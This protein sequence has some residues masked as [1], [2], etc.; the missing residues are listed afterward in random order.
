MQSHYPRQT[1]IVA[2]CAAITLFFLS[3]GILRANPETT[4]KV[5]NDLLDETQYEETSGFGTGGDAYDDLDD[6]AG[7]PAGG[8]GSGSKKIIYPIQKPG[9]SASGGNL[10][11]TLKDLAAGG[12]GG[13][14]PDTLGEIAPDITEEHTTS[15][16]A[17]FSRVI[18]VEH[19]DEFNKVQERLV[20]GEFHQAELIADAII[21]E[22]PGDPTGYYLSSW[23]NARNGKRE[24]ALEIIKRGLKIAP[25]H[26]GLQ[27]L[28]K[29]LKRKASNM[30]QKEVDRRRNQLLGTLTNEDAAGD[31]GPG[32]TADSRK[33]QGI[34][35]AGMVNPAMFGRGQMAKA[36]PHSA[37]GAA[38]AQAGLSAMRV[39]NTKT[40][41]TKLTEAVRRDPKNG[42]AWRLR[43]MAFQQAGQYT[44]AI[45][46]ANNALNINSRDH[47]AFLVRAKARTDIGQVEGA[48]TD[49]S[50][51]LQLKPNSAD[52]YA[53]RARLWHK[54][55]DHDKEADDLRQAANLDPA[56]QSL[57]RQAL[58]ENEQLA[59]RALGDQ[60]KSNQPSRALL[61]AGAVLLGLALI[62]AAFFRRRGQ[63][64]ITQSESNGIPGFAI[65]RKLG[66]GGMGE[67]WEAMDQALER[68]VAI[69][70]LIPE[71]ARVPRERKRFLKEAR[72]VAA[73]KHPGIIE[74]HQV[75][76][77]GE[78]L[79][80][81]F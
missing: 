24:E 31:V 2:S 76:E 42:V 60:A 1:R 67:V 29:L 35:M 12:V 40:A 39:G 19:V 63:T 50:T 51:A 43:A 70:K 68:R 80:L 79:Y 5:V 37:R 66:Q 26:E 53:T 52:A 16:Y 22:S 13:G 62:S 33:Y 14:L 30:A 81:V 25:D 6:N 45:R 71:I 58:Q 78:D 61:Y 10:E 48:L 46:D 75:V 11:A 3:T 41:I 54:T 36:L 32:F 73:L 57:Y 77:N 55:K 49:I 28:E 21:N 4:Q 56:F 9:S 47:W 27:N 18:P 38:A 20:M 17:E 64:T 7:T 15:G 69:K 72:T 34:Q 44:Q 23:V 59:Q 74:I 65:I 8:G